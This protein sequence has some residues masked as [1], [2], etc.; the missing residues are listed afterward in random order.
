MYYRWF[1]SYCV[2]KDIEVVFWFNGKGCCVWLVMFDIG[3]GMES[4]E[5]YIILFF[6]LEKGYFLDLV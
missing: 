3:I 4:S 5:I 2:E 6:I 1:L